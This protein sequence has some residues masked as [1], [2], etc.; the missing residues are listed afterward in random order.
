M[1]TF[2][3][4]NPIAEALEGVFAAIEKEKNKGFLI[5]SSPSEEKREQF[6]REFMRAGYH[7]SQPISTGK[8]AIVWDDS[9]LEDFRR[10]GYL[11]EQAVN[12]EQ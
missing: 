4:E 8:T 6:V 9:Q 1:Y 2:D 5:V 7:V 12:P 10:S 11:F 3:E